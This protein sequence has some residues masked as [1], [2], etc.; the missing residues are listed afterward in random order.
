M[1]G[2]PLPP[3]VPIHETQ[4]N[5]SLPEAGEQYLINDSPMETPSTQNAVVPTQSQM[6]STTSRQSLGKRSPDPDQDLDLMNTLF[7]GAAAMKKRRIQQDEEE[8]AC[9][10]KPS[11]GDE[12]VAEAAP[13]GS[14]KMDSETQSG[15]SQK[16][17]KS[18][19]E[20]SILIAAREVKEEEEKKKRRAEGEN[21]EID[22][23]ILKLKNPGVVETFELNQ[24]VLTIRVNA[25]G[26]EGDRWDPLWNG[27]PNFKKFRKRLPGTQDGDENHQ[28]RSVRG[29]VIIPLVEHKSGSG[30][31][32]SHGEFLHFPS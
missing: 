8:S 27:R 12:A 26:E 1:P 32:F 3:P 29:N 2:D 19:P 16:G 31:M 13:T 7:P 20:N 18:K 11:G 4:Y 24:R 21:E 17:K 23:I 25:Y 6:Q 5:S 28:M 14:A 10:P 22:E 9:R 15:K 30:S